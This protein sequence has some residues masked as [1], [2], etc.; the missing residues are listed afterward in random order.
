M[1]GQRMD[2]RLQ[3]IRPGKLSE[4]AASCG[5]ATPSPEPVL[6]IRPKRDGQPPSGEGTHL[7]DG[8]PAPVDASVNRWRKGSS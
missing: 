1:Y 2:N 7:P 8:M 3:G 5:A 4:P 6:G